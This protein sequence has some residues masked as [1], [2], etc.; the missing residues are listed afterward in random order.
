MVLNRKSHGVYIVLSLESTLS[1]IIHVNFFH[2]SY[3]KKSLIS[4]KQ[5]K[6]RDLTER[7]AL[8]G[9]WLERKGEKYHIAITKIRKENNNGH[10][11]LTM[12]DPVQDIGQGT[13]G[14]TTGSNM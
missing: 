11:S 7:N 3:L 8:P 5:Q 2:Q 13:Q 1:I 14:C 9:I 6:N 12:R 10:M 4:H